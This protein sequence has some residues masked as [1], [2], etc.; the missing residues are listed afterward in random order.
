M[1]LVRSVAVE[2]ELELLMELAAEQAPWLVPAWSR[3]D[4]ALRGILR[5]R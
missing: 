2:M 5:G 4:E 1:S 3:G